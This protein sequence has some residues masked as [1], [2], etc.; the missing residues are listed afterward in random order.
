MEHTLFRVS[1]KQ[2]KGSGSPPEIDGDTPHHYYSYFENEYGEQLIFT[3]DY[4]TKT[5]TLYH[6]DIGWDSPVPIEDGTA[7]GVVLHEAET[8]WLKACWLATVHART[9]L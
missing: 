7:S 8:L 6:G 1:N 4:E 9:G 3:Y 5:G 2:K